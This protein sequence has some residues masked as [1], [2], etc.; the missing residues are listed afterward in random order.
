MNAINMK[1]RKIAVLLLIVFATIFLY[2]SFDVGKVDVAD[3]DPVK[4]EVLKPLL[5]GL[6]TT[7][8]YEKADVTDISK[9]QVSFILKGDYMQNAMP[10]KLNDLHMK[11]GDKFPYMG[12]YW[13]EHE[14]KI[15]GSAVFNVIDTTLFTEE[16]KSA[17]LSLFYFNAD[18]LSSSNEFGDYLSDT[19]GAYRSHLNSISGLQVDFIICKEYKCMAEVSF[20]Q[21]SNVKVGG[22]DNAKAKNLNLPNGNNCFSSRFANRPKAYLLTLTCS[23]GAH[24]Q[25]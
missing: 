13:V 15:D 9:E 3:T 16:S 1:K 24:P 8:T 25:S 4:E 2:E 11:Y 14:G 7:K 10:D 22:L 6:D 12:V 19:E 5:T 23:K 21:E 18:L 20:D 17:S